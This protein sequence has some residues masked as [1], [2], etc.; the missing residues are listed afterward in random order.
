MSQ[1]NEVV[2]RTAFANW[3]SRDWEKWKAVHHADMVA[4]PPKDWPEADP[5]DS[6]DAWLER[7]LLMLEPWDEQRLQIDSL[8]TT[9][10]LVV[11]SF[12]WVASGRQSEVEVDIPIVGVYTVIDAKIARIEFFLGPAEALAAAG[13]RE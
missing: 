10:D 5:V 13:L 11:V 6:L 1:E 8:R 4:I 9:G 2:I 12:R 7:V 3:N